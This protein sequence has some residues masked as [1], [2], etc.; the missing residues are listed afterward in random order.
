MPVN[1]AVAAKAREERGEGGQSSKLFEALTSEGE[2]A[3][4]ES[5]GV[6][7][8]GLVGTLY[9]NGPGRWEAG[10]QALGHLFDGDGM[11]S[12][13]AIS[14]G[15]VRYRNRY[16]RTNHYLGARAGR[17]APQRGLGTLRRGGALAN[18]LRLPANV[19]NTSVVMH[20]GELLALWEAGN[21]HA[22]DP[23]T[24]ETLGRENFGGKLRW[25]GAF[26]AHPKVD[27]RSGDLYNFGF[28]VFPRPK[29]RCYRLDAKRQ[30]RRLRDVPLPAPGMWNHD[31]ALTERSLV[32]VLDPITVSLRHLP[33]VAA[34]LAPAD[35]ALR[36]RASRGTTVVV[37]GRDGSRPRVLQ[38]EALMHLHIVNAF[39]DGSDTVV[40]LVNWEMDW[41]EV[42]SIFHN[43][44]TE[45]GR[46]EGGRLTRLRITPQG[47]VLRETL[48]PGAGEF[49][50]YDW[51]RTAQRYR[52][53]Y[54]ASP[55]AASALPNA[56]VK[57][58][59]ESGS[60]VA[61]VLGA[62]NAVS[63]PIFVPAH[64]AAAED[65]GW[66]LTVAYDPE[67]HR[68]RLLVLDAANPEAEALY[69]GHLRHHVPMGFHGTFTRR[70]A[71]AA[72]AA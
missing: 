72:A 53:T 47:R 10:G 20:A 56:I 38:T 30:L 48:A 35:R 52:Y 60:E 64:A 3:I 69:V 28:E 17:G 24:L 23:D 43:F 71:G 25:M 57:C 62:E 16:V 55:R 33:A 14:G 34:G 37:V 7:P 26:S 11:L 41:D 4:E 32:F 9:R 46:L 39:E 36:Y 70:V 58:D 2:Y 67:R 18:A 22:L 27:P 31:M 29:L 65:E 68:S 45:I 21:P 40:D 63:E 54:L 50:Q 5:E 44:R 42:S 13:F 8:E 19:A 6:L 51:R 49:P 12:A 61:H 1:G 15:E 66:L 59:I